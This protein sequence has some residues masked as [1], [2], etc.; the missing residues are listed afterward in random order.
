M[1]GVAVTPEMMGLLAR[2]ARAMERFDKQR[3]RPPRRD[4]LTGKQW[5]V[6]FNLE[7]GPILSG[8]RTI[9]G[10]TVNHRIAYALERRGLVEREGPRG[11]MWVRLSP[12]GR[13]RVE[14]KW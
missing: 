9:P 11:A 1:T 3:P 2:C 10:A 13:K 8:E 7:R 5:M 14:Q 6:M 12:A 4:R